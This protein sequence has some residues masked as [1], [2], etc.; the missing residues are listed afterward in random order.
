[1]KLNKRA[2]RVLRFW[3][4]LPTKPWSQPS[5]DGGPGSGNWGHRGRPG[6]VGGSG[7]GGGAQYRGGRSDIKY[8][9]TRKDWLNG[10]KGEEQREAA[11]WLKSMAKK[12]GLDPKTNGIHAVEKKIVNGDSNEDLHELFHHMVAARKW[13]EN[14]EVLMKDNL[15]ATDMKVVMALIDKYGEDDTQRGMPNTIAAGWSDEDERCWTELQ[16]KAMGGASS[17]REIPEDLQYRAGLKERPKPK[18]TKRNGDWMDKST[19]APNGIL[20]HDVETQARN[21]LSDYFNFN[22]RDDLLAAEQEIMDDVTYN[23]SRIDF[24]GNVEEA[25]YKNRFT[26]ILNKPHADAIFSYLQLKGGA[27]GWDEVRIASGNV[28]FDTLTDEENK[29]LRDLLNKYDV[30][31]SRSEREAFGMF[32]DRAYLFWKP[33][34]AEQSDAIR[35]FQLKDKALGGSCTPKEEYEKKAQE[36]RAQ[37]EKNKHPDKIGKNG[38][39]AG[40]PMDFESADHGK[41]NPEVAG[42]TNRHG[43]YHVNCQ[44]CVVAYEARR[45]GYD[46]TAKGNSK[47][48]D[49]PCLTLSR[50]TNLAW[51]DPETGRSPKYIEHGRKSAAG[52]AKWFDENVK[53]GERYHFGWV[54]KYGGGHIVTV[55]RND[56]GEVCLF[57]PQDGFTRPRVVG[58]T[59]LKDYMQKYGII[60]VRDGVSM[61]DV[62]RVD[63]L[64]F[65]PDMVNEILL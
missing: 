50:N 56:K 22:S 6:L 48:D 42:E 61:A 51:V 8:V 63:N 29:E 34:K 35:Y 21:A 9:G 64:A 19:M 28:T 37:I 20:Y 18:A 12:H 31:D 62:L 25:K 14:G 58:K 49:D 39:T 4:S 7:A 59:A 11:N 23:P 57:D 32:E 27:L 47:A 10:L 16:I 54:S 53:Q 13:N 15:N 43:P 38:K 1:M 40:P 24:S 52:L 36:A 46:V 55:E 44:T 45:R 30:Q 33:K 60:F 65:N 26:T 3:D 2:G 17:D 41:A 5:E